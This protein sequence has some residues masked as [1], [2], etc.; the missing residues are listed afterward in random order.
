MLKCITSELPKTAGLVY[1][2]K[3]E[4]SWISHEWQN[5]FVYKHSTMYSTDSPFE[6]SHLPWPLYINW[7]PATRCSWLD[8]G[9]V[10]WQRTFS[11][12][13]IRNVCKRYF[14]Y[15]Y[16]LA[17]WL[18]GTLNNLG[19]FTTKANYFITVFC[20]FRLALISRNHL[21]VLSHLTLVLPNSLLTSDLNS[22][23]F[24]GTFVWSILIICP[25]PNSPP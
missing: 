24:L 22:K 11:Q 17:H 7:T 20:N 6:T 15:P 1:P 9:I 4:T 12:S 25:I 21:Y 5:S 8:P 2:L 18:Y 3:Y 23:I 10:P 14:H 19:P 16:L 13:P